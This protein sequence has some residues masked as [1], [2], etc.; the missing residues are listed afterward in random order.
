MLM[1]MSWYSNQ[2]ELN[3]PANNAALVSLLYQAR[4]KSYFSSVN[5]G[6]ENADSFISRRLSENSDRSE[7]EAG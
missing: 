5:S 4:E 1:A 7:G 3:L 6:F 2:V